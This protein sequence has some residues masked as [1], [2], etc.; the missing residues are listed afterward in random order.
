MNERLALGQFGTF[1]VENYGDLLY[2]ALLERMFH[3]RNETREI[4]SYSLVGSNS[5]QDSGC[6]TQ[7]I[8]KLFSSRFKP[9]HTLIVGGGDLLR[10]DW[11]TVASHYRSICLRQREQALPFIWRGL[12]MKGLTSLWMPTTNFAGCT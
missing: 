2:P 10:T 8:R 11:N 1:D 9:P 4:T 12:F 5:L 7:P 6:R 3:Q